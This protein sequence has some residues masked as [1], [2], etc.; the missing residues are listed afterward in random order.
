[1]VMIWTI[2]LIA[3][4]FKIKSSVTMLSIKDEQEWKLSFQEFFSDKF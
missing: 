3:H 2:E 1:M 4:F